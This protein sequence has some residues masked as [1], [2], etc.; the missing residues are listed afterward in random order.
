MERAQKEQL[1]RYL[2]AR[3]KRETLAHL[4]DGDLAAYEREQS[5]EAQRQVDDL[6][7]MRR[8]ARK[9]QSA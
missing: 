4:R 5:R 9:N 7:L 6:F 3:Q 8:G 1:R 2:L